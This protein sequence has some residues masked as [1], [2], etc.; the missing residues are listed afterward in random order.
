[1]TTLETTAQSSWPVPWT[2]NSMRFARS[3]LITDNGISMSLVAENI[4]VQ[5]RLEVGI[6]IMNIIWTFT[7]LG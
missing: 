1:M 4:T 2:V 7:F 3:G 5:I 6:T